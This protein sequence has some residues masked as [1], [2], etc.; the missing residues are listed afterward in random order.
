MRPPQFEVVLAPDRMT[1]VF[2]S[3]IIQVEARQAVLVVTEAVSN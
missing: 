1:F 3:P 2:K